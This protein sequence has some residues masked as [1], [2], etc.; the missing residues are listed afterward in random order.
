MP[1]LV[2]IVERH[3]R[4]K[5]KLDESF[6]F[7]RWECFPKASP[8]IYFEMECGNC[9]LL[10]SGKNKGFP[11]YRKVSERKVFV[12]T[13]AESKDII[14]Q[15][16][17]E[18]GNCRDCMGDGKTIAKVSVYTETEYRECKRCAGT[19]KTHLVEA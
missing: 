2:P 16:E 9:P 12:I 1:L 6:N 19:G 7:F 4:R 11:N 10:K 15:Y 3:L 5:E 8:I 17:D 13:V 18:T 14:E